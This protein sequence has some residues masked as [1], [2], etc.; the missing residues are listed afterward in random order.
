MSRLPEIKNPAQR[1]GLYYSTLEEGRADLVGLYWCGDRKCRDMGL[2]PNEV[3]AL[4]K[5]EA[6]AR[7]ALVQLRRV[8]F[9]ERVEESTIGGRSTP[10]TDGNWPEKRLACEGSV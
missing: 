6:Y 2:V 1:L 4:A 5:Y 10:C 8:P 9:G 3:A 7:N